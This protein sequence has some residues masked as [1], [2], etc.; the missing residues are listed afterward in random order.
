[1]YYSVERVLARLVTTERDFSTVISPSSRSRYNLPKSKPK[2]KLNPLALFYFSSTDIRCITYIRTQSR[3]CQN[4][5][6]RHIPDTHFILDF[7]MNFFLFLHFIIFFGSLC[8]KKLFEAIFLIEKFCALYPSNF[9]IKIHFSPESRIMKFLHQIH[10][11]VSFYISRPAFSSRL[12]FQIRFSSFVFY[13][14]FFLVFSIFPVFQYFVCTR[15]SSRSERPR[16]SALILSPFSILRGFHRQCR[17]YEHT[18]GCI[19]ASAVP[20]II[21]IS[22]KFTNR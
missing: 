6:I 12:F 20:T 5:S 17:V 7:G 15:K 2:P 16:Q 18:S 22:T 11:F 3:S 21:T 8:W 10:I 9:V 4:P 14:P 13:S 1:M 19:L